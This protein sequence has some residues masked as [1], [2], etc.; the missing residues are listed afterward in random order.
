VEGLVDLQYASKLL[1][2]AEP[3]KG[4]KVV[5]EASVPQAYRK[6]LAGHQMEITSIAVGKTKNKT[7]VVSASL[8]GTVR[9]WDPATGTEDHKLILDSSVGRAY[10]ACT[11]PKAKTNLMVCGGQDGN[12]TLWDLDAISHAPIREFKDGHQ[13]PISCVAFSPDGLTCATGGEDRRICFWD[14]TTGDLRYKIPG[15]H[16]GMITTLEFTPQGQLVTAGKDNRMQLWTL[17]K[18]RYRLEKSSRATRSGDVGTLG[19]SPDGRRV[20]FD[21]G[22]SL[23]ILSIPD[24]RYEGSLQYSSGTAGFTSFALFS[25]DASLI[26]TA[27]GP[28]GNVQLWRTPTGNSQRGYEFRQ[29]LPKAQNRSPVTCAAFAPDNSFLVTGYRNRDIFLWDV[30]KPAELEEKITARVSLVGY[31]VESNN[32]VRIVADLTSQD[33]PLRPGTTATLVI[34]PSE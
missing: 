33:K 23:Q 18:D 17:G 13:G 8:D 3:K 6:P 32:Q 12:A 15:A 5:V 22:K 31:T 21:Y 2:G 11:G 25:P 19:V 1:N 24:A 10:L 29:L 27:G 14:T 34:D 7:V 4:M 16:N 9:I 20:L 26:L 28:E 30:P